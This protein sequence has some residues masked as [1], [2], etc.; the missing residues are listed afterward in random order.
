MDLWWISEENKVDI[1]PQAWVP[2][3]LTNSA[4]C[5]MKGCIQSYYTYCPMAAARGQHPTLG[6]CSAS[7]QVSK[8]HAQT[9][10]GLHAVLE[11]KNCDVFL[12]RVRLRV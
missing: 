6:L 9:V 8:Q 2:S 11:V 3:P 7:T 10:H 5:P 4:Q 1:F 12:C